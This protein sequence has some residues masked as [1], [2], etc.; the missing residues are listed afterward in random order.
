[1]PL[2]RDDKKALVKDL[3]EKIQNSKS[4][5]FVSYRGISVSEMD[6][7]RSK[8]RETG[9]EFKITR[10]TLMKIAAKEAGI[11]DE[12]PSDVLDGPVAMAFSMEDAV[13]GPKALFNFSKAN[14]NLKLLGALYEEGVLSSEQAIALAKTPSREELLAKLVGS[15]K[16]PISGFHGTLHGVMSGFVRVVNAYKD[17]KP[18]EA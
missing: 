11:A 5:T 2:T 7:L 14:E 10:K 3:T 4:V 16:S 12:I 15:M 9:S 6:D 18:Q 13:S 17:T 8:M 1:M